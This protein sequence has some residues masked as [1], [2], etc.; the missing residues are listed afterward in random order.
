MKAVVTGG[1]GFIGSHIAARLVRDGHEVVVLDDLS[2]GRMSN[3]DP[4]LDHIG[5]IQASVADAD[6]CAEAVAGAEVVF[7]EAALGSVPRSVANPLATHE[8]N[9][10]GTLNVLDAARRAGV[11]RVVYAA[12]S[13]AYGN[14]DVLPKHEDLMPR[15]LSPYAVSKLAGENYC[16]AFHASY[17]L[18][19]IAL[20]YFNVFGPRQ[21]PES[22]YAAVIP[23]FVTAALEGRRPTINGDGGQTRD[24]T[25]VDNVVEANMLALQAR[26]EACG[27]VFNV[28]CGD[29]I[30]V[31]DLWQRITRIVGAR[32][33]P[34]FAP[35]RTGDV[36]DSLA[37]LQRAREFLG[38]APRVSLQ[39]GLERTIR[40]FIEERDRQGSARVR[41]GRTS[42]PARRTQEE[43]AA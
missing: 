41:K 26:P 36:R 33:E 6:A 38:Y 15:P 12:S 39:D 30:S 40:A 25:H 9:L 29:R 3:L 1:A 19:T 16:R 20:R 17:G 7:H 18:E 8:A 32:I 28:G 24:F 5:F 23:L 35:A 11:R 14:T 27:R 13:S 10:T 2:T 4:I 21:D 34:D 43:A 31:L 22:Q 42:R 37:D